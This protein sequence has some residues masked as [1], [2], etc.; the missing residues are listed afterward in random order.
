[1][2][3]K[4]GIYFAYWT[5]EWEG[6]F[7]YYVNKVARLG[8]DTLEICPANLVDMPVSDRKAIKRAA[9]DAGID[10]TYCIGIPRQY[11]IASEDRDVRNAGVEYQKK[12]I[13][14]VSSMDGQFMGG[15][16]YSCWP[17]AFS[18]GITDKTPYWNRSVDNMKKIAAYAEKNGVTLCMEVVNR[19][20][21]ILLN[22]AYE[23]VQY[24]KDVDSPS[25]RIL[26]DA[27]HMNIEEDDFIDAI[28]TA[29][30]YLSHFHIGETNRKTPGKGKMDWDSICSGLNQIGYTGHVVMEP[31]IKMGGTVGGDI[32]MWRDLSGNCDEAGLDMMAKDACAFIRRKLEENR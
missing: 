24:C 10:L 20:E 11:D 6:D 26:L 17:G 7:I 12:L 21:Q 28:K 31:F 8:F 13:D 1:M 14:V 32:K 2:N 22:Q 29:G 16:L 27:F 4:I 5:H 23:A 19:F 3:N 25:C 9:D 18:V 15:I 30:S